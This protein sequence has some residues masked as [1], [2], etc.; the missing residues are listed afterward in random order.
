MQGLPCRAQVLSPLSELSGLRE[1]SLRRAA[2]MRSGQGL[3]EVCQLTGLKRL[4]LWVDSKASDL[5]LQLIQLKQLTWLEF[6][7]RIQ[8]NTA[9]PA[10]G[11]ETFSCTVRGAF[12]LVATNCAVSLSVTCSAIAL[13]SYCLHGLPNQAVLS[14]MASNLIA[15]I[16][17]TEWMISS[18]LISYCDGHALSRAL[19]TSTVHMLFPAPD[20]LSL[21]LCRGL[22][23]SLCG[24]KCCIIGSTKAYHEAS[25]AVDQWAAA[26]LANDVLAARKYIMLLG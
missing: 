4:H 22:V 17:W 15:I 3:G 25:A 19:Y 14:M 5:W 13:S 2:G 12:L 7:A 8:G 24:S 23:S 10:S 9:F 6:G 1:I 20:V 26:A 21:S 11:A 18:V 16:S